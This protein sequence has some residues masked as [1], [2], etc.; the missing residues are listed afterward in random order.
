MILLDTDTCIEILRGN[1]K[2]ID[3]RL[4]TDE[5]VAISFMT[6]GE[7]YYGAEK[8][9]N[10]INNKHLVDEFILAVDV[11]NTDM[12]ILKKFGELKAGMEISRFPLSDADI[13]IAATCLSKCNKLV[14]GN[15]K[16]FDKIENL[17]IENWI[18]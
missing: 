16:H 12:E 14:T 6:V 2:V 9:K 5:R 18:R 15:I 11:I 17:T 7:L 8:S 4:E 1:Q 3:K 13:L 10:R